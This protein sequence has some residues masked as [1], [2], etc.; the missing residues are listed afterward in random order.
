V[1]EQK[2]VNYDGNDYLL[3][4]MPARQGMK[5]GVKVIKYAGKFLGNALMKT[6]LEAKANPEG[7]T[8]FFDK[9][10]D[11][12]LPML[13]Q[14]LDVLDEDFGDL[15]CDVVKASVK[16]KELPGGMDSFEVE[17][18]GAPDKLL[19]LCFHAVILN[20]QDPLNRLLKKTPE[21]ETLKEETVTKKSP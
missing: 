8:S 18:A 16:L 12:I 4:Q 11:E 2:K 1:L 7:M 9:E 17:F 13:E 10:V 20:Y 5:L 19:F 6:V 15:I 21:I 3:E 14:A